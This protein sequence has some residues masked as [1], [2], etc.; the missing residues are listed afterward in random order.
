[1][2]LAISQTDQAR[3]LWSRNF[4]LYFVGRQASMLGDS[5]LP[6]AMSVTLLGL[7]YGAGT[8]GV[9]LAARMAPLALLV[10]FGG[11][12]A[13]RFHPRPIM[14]GADAVR[15]AIHVVYCLVLVSGGDLPLW[16]FIVG[17]MINGAATAMFQPGVSSM[18]PQVTRHVHKANG[19]LRMAEGAAGLAGPALAGV[20]VAV[21]GTGVIFGIAGGAFLIS[22]TALLLLRGIGAPGRP[23][24]GQAPMWQN[25]VEGWQEFRSRTW[26]WKVIVI[27]IPNGIFVTGP[28]TPLSAAAIIGAH[29]KSA[30]GFAEA[31]FGAGL[32]VGGLVAT[33]LVPPR[34]LLGGGIAMF[35]FAAGPL[36][37]ATGGPLPAILGGFLVAGLGWSYWSVNWTTAV[38]THVPADKLN[39]VYAYDVAGSIVA[40]P[41]GQ[42][43]SG[44]YAALLG[45][46]TTLYISSVLSLGVAL[47]LLLDPAIRN[48]RRVEP[49]ARP[50]PAPI[51]T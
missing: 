33:R 41:I 6:I 8:V 19:V 27:W 40:I 2:A 29:G 25:L 39:R 1:M 13:D 10:L 4:G 42:A 14:I 49:A 3:V 36:A 7:G 31:A 34:L 37:A 24:S 28:W 12:L 23:A 16:C 5:I 48:L 50:E 26:L 43:L 32:V 11:V 45:L 35:L 21:A 18:V 9:V 22:G 38:Q 15:A 30:F 51:T 47:A 44:G 20:V 17:S 46:H